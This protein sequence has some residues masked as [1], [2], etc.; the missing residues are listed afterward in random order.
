MK[1]MSKAAAIAAG[2]IV[3]FVLIV[4]SGSNGAKPCIDRYNEAVSRYAGAGVSGA[5]GT[6]EQWREGKC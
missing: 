4:M 3:V 6:Y 2:V 5:A 1:S